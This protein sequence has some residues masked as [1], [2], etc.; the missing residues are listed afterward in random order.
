VSIIEKIFEKKLLLF[1]CLSFILYGNTLFNGYALDDQFVTE[2]NYTNDGLKSI[3]R[4]FTSYYAEKDGNNNYEYRPLVKLSFAIEHQIFGIKPWVSHL[5]NIVLYAMCLNLL[6]K[7]LQLI[8]DNY[9]SLFSLL[10]VIIFSA[11]PTHTEV[12]ASLKNRDIL[13]CFIFCMLTIL[14]LNKYI[15]TSKIFFFAIA[16][17]TGILAFLSKLDASVYIILTP[18]ILYKK[19][20]LKNWK[21]L[22]VLSTFFVGFY[23]L[24]LAKIIFLD[25]TL[26]ERI[27]KYEE[28]PLHFS[29]S[30]IDNI[31]AAFNSLGFYI[32]SIILPNNLSSYYGYDTIPI[33]NFFSFY[34]IIGY[35]SL[36]VLI[37]FFII[38]LKTKSPIWYAIV[39]F[40]ASVSIYLNLIRP[41]PGIVA[42]RFLF[43]PSIG[44]AIFLVFILFKLTNNLNVKTFKETS[45]NFKFLFIIILVIYSGISISRNADWKNRLIL[46]ERDSKKLPT[47]VVL[48]LLYSNEVLVNITKNSS[49]YTEK[50]ITQQI[51]QS[52]TCLNNVLKIDS[53]NTTALNNLAYLKQNI[54]NDFNSALYYYKKAYSIDSLKYEVHYNLTYCLYR[55]GNKKEA[56]ENIIK[57]Y[58]KSNSENQQVLDLMCYILIDNKD[59]NTGFSIFNDLVKK[60]PQNSNLNIILGN[61]YLATKDSTNAKKY[62]EIAL[63]LDKK[64]IQLSEIIS[65]LS[66]K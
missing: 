64:N 24:K 8:F 48:N 12:V 52:I 17:T 9:T 40:G 18:F 32:K 37:Y 66:K 63:D 13:L 16:I 42:D 34:A 49:N 38:D 31:S 60:Q 33:F 1:F 5:I 56:Q 21:S 39:F 36:I 6:F 46:F 61:F 44:W 53:L 35:V 22:L 7:V 43:S 54:F 20:L 27:L 10:I 65:R 25:K 19:H 29:H 30:F 11:H 15:K 58:N 28:N 51:K 26:K 14:Y 3:K 2:K 41:A 47:S 4:I 62:Y 55:T 59:Y 50:E 23:M 45:I 57:L